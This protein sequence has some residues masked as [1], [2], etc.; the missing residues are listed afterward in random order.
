VTLYT[1]ILEKFNLRTRTYT[2]TSTL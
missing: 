2:H 1:G